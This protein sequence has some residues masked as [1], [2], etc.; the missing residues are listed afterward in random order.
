MTH[1]EAGTAATAE[2]IA[3]PAAGESLVIDS[4]ALALF[5]KLA[6]AS[7]AV[8]EHEGTAHLVIPE[9][10]KHIDL[11]A[12]VEKAAAVPTR[13]QGTVKLGDLDSFLTYV[14]QHG[15][16]DRTYVYADVDSRSLTAV[17][18]DHRPHL[19]GDLPGWRDHRAVYTAELSP[20]FENWKKHDRNQFDQEAFAIFIEDNIADVIEP[21]GEVLLKVALTL[22]AKTDVNF[23]SARR[24]DNGQVQFTY[25]ENTTASA[26][27]G[28]I[29]IP[30]EFTLGMRLFKGGEGYK[31]KARLKYR[32]GS[33]KLKFWYELDRPH[34]AI[35]DAFKSYVEQAREADCTLL[36]GKAG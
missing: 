6:V 19:Y 29:E 15:Q 23:S 25:E 33:G 14:E 17:I 22:Q 4:S 20:E 35:E 12:A 1:P 16:H 31:L 11:T 9:G 24:L 26:A 8:T 10:Y 27:N 3:A 36:V 18:N 5:T 21:A 30:R 13:K 7:T 2:F 34:I 28:A 32:I